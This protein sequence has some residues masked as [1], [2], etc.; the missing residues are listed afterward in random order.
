[1]NEMSGYIKLH[2]SFKNWE[3]Y[4]DT[5]AKSVYLHLILSANY[6]E[7]VWKGITLKCGQLI[8]STLRLSE[9]LGLS[10]Q[11]IRTALNKLQK[12]GYIT[13]ET[14]NKYS[15]ITVE[16]WEIYQGGPVAST[17]RPASKLTHKPQPQQQQLKNINNIKN[18]EFKKS[19]YAAQKATPNAAQSINGSDKY[20]YE[21]LRI[22]SRERIRRIINDE[23]L[24]I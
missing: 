12:T 1:M 22:K 18:K 24:A 5:A 20:D 6:T 7:D 10:V 19:E 4:Q 16:N 8:T 17:Y 23:N 21:L 3:W 13:I 11:Q 15:L 9:T 2:R 14:T